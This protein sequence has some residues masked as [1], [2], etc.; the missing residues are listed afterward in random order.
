MP[1]SL[2]GWLIHS[3]LRGAPQLAAETSIVSGLSGRYAVAL[4]DLAK[5]GGDLES[6]AAD[7]DSI[8]AMM[9]D[10]ADLMRLVRSPVISREDQGKAM[11][12]VMAQ[13]EIGATTRRFIGLVARNR[14]LFSLGAMIGSFRQLLASHRGEVTAEV[15]SAQALDADQL[16]AVSASLAKAVGREVNVTADVDESL[17]AGLVVKVGSRMIDNSLR[18]KL[19]NLQFAMKEVG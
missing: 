12:A 4:F 3:K 6:V 19:Q 1:V 14:R 15:T 16:S 9:R 8:D 11:D 7:L 13:A 5:E 17:I 18:T 2:A 10:S